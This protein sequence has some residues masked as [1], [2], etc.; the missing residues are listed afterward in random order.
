MHMIKCCNL[1]PPP[2]KWMTKHEVQEFVTNDGMRKRAQIMK[3]DFGHIEFVCMNDF[4]VEQCDGHSCGVLACLKVMHCFGDIGSDYR[5]ISKDPNLRSFIV[6]RYKE[7]LEIYCLR[8]VN[9]SDW[10][11]NVDEYPSSLIMIDPKEKIEQVSLSTIVIDHE[12]IKSDAKLKL[13]A[14]KIDGK[15]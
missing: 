15:N 12:E 1:I 7:L 11:H 5:A 4:C 8:K 6:R 9:P 2:Q 3:L 10:V 14:K 13:D